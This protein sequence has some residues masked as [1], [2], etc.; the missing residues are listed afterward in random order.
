MRVGL[1]ASSDV[2]ILTELLENVAKIV[3]SVQGSLKS[4]IIS[5]PALSALYREDIIAAAIYQGIS[6]LPS[7]HWNRD[8]PYELVAA[9]SGHGLGL[10]KSYNNLKKCRTEEAQLPWRRTVLFEYTELALVLHSY[11]LSIVKCH[12]PIHPT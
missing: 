6:T 3:P 11:G 4:A 7:L 2:T 1:P 12:G 10:C 8:Q 5:Y 9:Y